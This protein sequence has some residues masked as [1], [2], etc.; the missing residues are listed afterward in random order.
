MTDK[1]RRSPMGVIFLTLFLDLVGFSIIFPLFPSMLNYYLEMEQ[2]GTLLTNLLDW[3]HSISGTQPTDG[4]PSPQVVAL[5]GGVLGSLYSLLQFLFAPVWGLASDRLG[6]R[7][8][9]LLTIAGIAVSYVL[10]FFSGSFTRLLIS[11]LIGGIMS[12]NISAATAA[13]ADV[14]TAENRAKGMGMVGAAFGLGFIMGPAIGGSLSLADLT[15]MAP[16]LQRFGVNP[17]S[18]AAGAACLLSVL[19]FIWVYRKFDETLSEEQRARARQSTRSFNPVRR[20]HTV[21]LPGVNTTN[22]ANFLFIFSFSGMEFSLTF[23]AADRFDFGMLEIAALLSFAGL[24]LAFVQGGLIRRLAPRYGE[25]NLA[26]A[27]LVINI[28]GLVVIGTA[29]QAWVLYA[30]VFIMSIGAAII[31]PSL[32][33]LASLYTPPDRQGEILGIFSSMG[34]LARAGGPIIAGVIYWRFDSHSAYYAGAAFLVLPLLVTL[35]LP[36][37]VKDDKKTD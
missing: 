10:W 35:S 23:L 36:R 19:N 7:P 34:A 8:V 24:T 31:I 27:G 6:R 33:T 17:F 1:K 25:V 9:L 5:F 13:I 29:S 16:S 11:R 21:N 30:G 20:L 4:V 18:I 22:F 12:G 15:E 32:R 28:P 37:P 14:T 3:L 2:G 26:R